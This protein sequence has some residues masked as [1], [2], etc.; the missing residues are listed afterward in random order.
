MGAHPLSGSSAS[1]FLGHPVFL[2]LMP[3][4]GASPLTAAW[5]VQVGDCP[6]SKAWPSHP[7]SQ[8]FVSSFCRTAPCCLVISQD[9]SG[10]D[11]QSW[12]WPHLCPLLTNL[13]FLHPSCRLLL[14]SVTCRRTL[15]G[16]AFSPP[17]LG[18]G[19]ALGREP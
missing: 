4:V 6:L 2:L 17:R 11:P 14:R 18:L 3:Q 12:I 15:R 13:L 16:C 1:V 9:H 7:S 5:T 19:V 8:A 10:L